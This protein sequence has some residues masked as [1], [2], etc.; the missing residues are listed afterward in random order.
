MQDRQAYRLERVR[1]AAEVTLSHRADAVRLDRLAQ[2]GSAKAFLPRVHGPV[3]EVVFLN[4]AGGLTGGDRLSYRLA[5]GAGA[6]VT[7]TTQ[8]AERIY[9]STGDLA[10]VEVRLLAEAGARLHWLPQETILFDRAR[11]AR[12]TRADLAGDAELLLVETLVLGRAAMGEEVRSLDLLDR[13]EVWRDG[14]PVFLE[15][16]RLGDHS[17][18]RAALIGAHRAMATLALLA[19]G[20]EDAVGPLRAALGG[21]DGVEA[22]VSGWDGR[23]LVRLAAERAAA[24]RQA[25]RVVMEVVRGA[26]LPRVWQL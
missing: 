14:R 6:A 21:V 18:G 22:G 20:A 7:G 13:R 12:H 8:T 26:P 9:S 25:L 4:T 17:Q 3:P 10:E 19:R 11:L 1:G 2:Q 16:L 5:V 23:C 15:P 24:L